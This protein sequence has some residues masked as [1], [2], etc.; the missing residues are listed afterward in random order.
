[1]ALDHFGCGDMATASAA[2]IFQSPREMERERERKSITKNK[3]DVVALAVY[4]LYFPQ[5]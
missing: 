5:G 2:S 1:M 3:K 4:M